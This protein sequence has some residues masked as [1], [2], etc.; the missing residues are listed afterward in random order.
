MNIYMLGNPLLEQDSLP[1]RILPE[2]KKLFP[3]INFS[4]IDPTEEF[5]DEENL[6]II[7][8]EMNTNKVRILD[9]LE[10]I[11]KIQSSPALSLHDF[12]LGFQLKL[13]KKLGKINKITLICVPSESKEEKLL[14]ELKPIIDAMQHPS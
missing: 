7:D 4:E 8:T 5:P 12:D 10:D 1:V 6:I 11:E 3:N 9:K 13:A 2:L 14:E